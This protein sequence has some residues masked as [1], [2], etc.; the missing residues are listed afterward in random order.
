M[1]NVAKPLENLNIAIKSTFLSLFYIHA[2]FHTVYPGL[3]WFVHMK[4]IWVVYFST[5]PHDVI[6][7]MGGIA[8]LY[9]VIN[10]HEILQNVY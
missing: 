3:S 4:R 9:E 1:K 8:V 6:S 5:T 7:N 10:M 2:M